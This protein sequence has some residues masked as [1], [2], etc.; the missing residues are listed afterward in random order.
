[1]R[2]RSIYPLL[3][4]IVLLLAACN[5]PATATPI[6]LMVFGDPAELAAYEELA[7]AF[8]AHHPA[9][10]LNLISIPDQGDYRRRLGIDLAAGTPADVVLINYR[11]YAAFAARGALEPLDAYLARSSVLEPQ[12]F[13]PQA[14]TPFQF[15]GSLYCIPQNL[16][17]LVIYYNQDLFK[18]AGVP[19][20]QAGWTWDDLLRTAQV[21][22]RD[23]D[24]DGRS[25]QHGLGLE[26]SLLRA[27]PF[28][29][30]NGGELV[31]NPAAPTRL[32]LDQP[33]A[34]QALQWFVDLQVRHHVV[35]DA[36]E[37]QAEA[38][39][40]RFLN[41]RLAM[42]LNSRRGVPTYRTISGFRWDVATLPVGRE[43]AGI[44]HADGYCM[45]AAGQQKAA[46]WQLIEFANGSVG[47]TIIA[48]SGRTVP[49]LRAVATSAAFLDPTAPPQSSHIFL[50]SIATLRAVPLSPA[51]A[52]IEDLAG[53][54]LTRAFYGQVDL[55]TAIAE[56]IR[57]TTPLW[58]GKR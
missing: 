43:A 11:R 41:G 7:S 57:R 19:F 26:P 32:A 53:A 35:P 27:A 1:M 39:E 37:E 49:S 36:V 34:R 24:G 18:A 45:P 40:S 6:S 44:L 48:R 12:Q 25:D 21:L 8:R 17:S 2:L 9:I 20:P 33:A 14:L 46:A 29:W 47:Q 22:T 31:D 10:P 42:Y 4:L 13:Y 54:E 52:E 30:Q 3:L 56:A 58:Q 55:D 38:S 28:I 15:N 50:D 16:S 51:W 23:L 5:G